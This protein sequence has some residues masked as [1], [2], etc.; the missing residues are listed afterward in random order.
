MDCDEIGAF[1]VVAV[2]LLAGWCAYLDKT[3][4]AGFFVGID[5]VALAAVFAPA[6]EKSTESNGST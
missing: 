5:V 4:I 3:W 1:S 2:L 6:K